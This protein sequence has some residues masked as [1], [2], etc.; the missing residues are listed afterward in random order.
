MFNFHS[1]QTWQVLKNKIPGSQW[2]FLF[3]LLQTLKRQGS[4]SSTPSRN[5]DSTVIQIFAGDGVLQVRWNCVRVNFQARWKMSLGWVRLWD[6]IEKVGYRWERW[7]LIGR[8]RFSFYKRDW[9]EDGSGSFVRRRRRWGVVWD[10]KKQ[11]GWRKVGCAQ[12]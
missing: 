2:H 11:V 1:F 3:F 7:V 4:S 8:L 6:G 5:V 12:R 9:N 10:S